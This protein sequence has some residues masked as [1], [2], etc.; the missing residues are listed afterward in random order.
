MAI[1]AFAAAKHL[2]RDFN[3][4]AY[5]PPATWHIAFFHDGT[6][7]TGNNYSRIAVTADSTNFPVITTNT[8]AN[9]VAFTTPQ[10]TGGDW[11]E[12]DEVRLYDDPTAGDAW[13]QES[14]D[15]PFTLLVG[16]TRTFEIGAL[17]IKY[18]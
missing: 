8:M 16:Q 14:L 5:T 15:E 17:R 12:A 7:L 11:L 6:E 18:I 10:A 9:G 3:G 4:A 1:T 2:N 13:Y